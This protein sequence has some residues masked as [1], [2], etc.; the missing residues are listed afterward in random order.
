MM[1]GCRKQAGVMALSITMSAASMAAPTGEAGWVGDA[2]GGRIAGTVVPLSER[3]M[4]ATRGR[5]APLVAYIGAVVGLDLALAGFFWGVYIPNY[6]GG[7]CS[8]CYY[9]PPISH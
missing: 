4:R 1:Q 2:F 9:T 6:G 3:D 8:S 5:F 7:G